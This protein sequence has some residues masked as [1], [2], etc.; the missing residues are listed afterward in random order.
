[1]KIAIKILCCFYDKNHFVGNAPT[2]ASH[3]NGS[4]ERWFLASVADP[5]YS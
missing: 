1:M 3:L 4:P 2:W 5:L